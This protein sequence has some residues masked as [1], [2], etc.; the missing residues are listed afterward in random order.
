MD[1]KARPALGGN[2]RQPWLNFSDCKCFTTYECILYPG[3]KTLIKGHYVV[4]RA[5]ATKREHDA[6]PDF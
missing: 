2:T 3:F 1:L 4:K 5:K 6:K